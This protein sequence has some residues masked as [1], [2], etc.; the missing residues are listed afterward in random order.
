VGRRP[1]RTST[2]M[3]WLPKSLTTEDGVPVKVRACARR[4]GKS[5]S[6]AASGSDRAA[7]R[8]PVCRATVHAAPDQ[9]FV[10]KGA[11]E[12][13]DRALGQ[14]RVHRSAPRVCPRLRMKSRRGFERRE[15]RRGYAVRLSPTADTPGRSVRRAVGA[16]CSAIAEPRRCRRVGHFQSRWPL[17]TSAI[18]SCVAVA[19]NWAPPARIWSTAPWAPSTATIGNEQV[20]GGPARARDAD[21]D[22]VVGGEE[23]LHGRGGWARI[24]S[25]A[26]CPESAS[27]SPRLVTTM[28]NWG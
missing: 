22:L 9:T 2:Q 19:D 24:S 11:N 16:G 1:W 6:T 10:F 28:L 4:H 27:S 13:G 21:G 3:I 25:A 20:C 14:A 5:R 18:G 7:Q 23:S 17:A 12:V 15:A 8:A 26:L